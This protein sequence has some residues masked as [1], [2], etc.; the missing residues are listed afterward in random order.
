MTVGSGG[1][2]SSIGRTITHVSGTFTSMSNAFDIISD[3]KIGDEI[4]TS[5]SQGLK[6]VISSVGYYLSTFRA[7]S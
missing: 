5:S 4:Y 2:T 7:R 6:V 3:I 1:C